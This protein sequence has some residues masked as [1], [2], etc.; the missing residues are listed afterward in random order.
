MVAKARAVSVLSNVGNTA[1]NISLHLLICSFLSY[2]T[3]TH[4]E[5][6]VHGSGLNPCP[7]N[8]SAGTRKPK[9]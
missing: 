5:V 4:L 2:S 3:F 6:Y 8:G 7:V 9:E 1:S